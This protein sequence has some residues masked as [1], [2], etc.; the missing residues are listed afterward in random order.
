M[1]RWW[2]GNNKAGAETGAEGD[3][4][5]KETF[6]EKEK[7][8]STKNVELN[9]HIEKNDDE[10]EGQKKKDISDVF[11]YVERKSM[12]VILNHVENELGAV[13]GKL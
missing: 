2:G 11:R 5:K 6:A 12:D 3:D 1:T 9:K 4:N 10:K 8:I 7:A 13:D